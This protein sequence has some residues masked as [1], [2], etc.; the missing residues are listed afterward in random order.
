MR[1]RRLPA[2]ALALAL[3][4]GV[5][6]LGPVGSTGAAFS[7]TSANGNNSYSV[8]PD[9]VA[10]TVNRTV[11]AESGGDPTYYSEVLADAP[12]G[13][14]RL[15]ES[16]GTTAADSSGN[17]RNGTYSGTYTLGA[18]G[19][20]NA[21][22][23]AVSF[24]GA[25]SVNINSSTLQPSNA[26]TVEAWVK[27]AS[28][29]GNC[30]IFE[31][32]ANGFPNTS[33]L[34]DISGG[35]F[36]CRFYKW[37]FLNQIQSNA[38]FTADAWAHVAC[39][40]NG[41]TLRMYVNGVQQTA[42]AALSAPIDTGTGASRIGRL[43]NGTNPFY[44]TIDEVAVY[45]T[46]LSGTRIS[47]HYAAAGGA[48]PDAVRSCRYYYAYAGAT[49]TGN[50]ASGV[51]SL[52]ADLSS[53]SSGQS[54]V[55]L[56]GGSYPMQGVTYGYRSGPRLATSAAGS[57]TYSMT[58]TDNAANTRVQTGFPATVVAAASPVS[59][60]YLTGLEQGVVS[61]NAPGV[62]DSVTATG[63][64]ADATTRRNGAYSLRIAPANAA[65][66]ATA[67]AS[68][69]GSLAVIRFAVRLA[70]LPASTVNLM[71]LGAAAGNPAAVLAY[72][73][74]TG[75][76]GVRFESGAITTG[77]VAPAAGTWYVIDMK[78]DLN[79]R[80][81]NWRIDGVDQPP[82]TS[83]G[84]AASWANLTFGTGSSTVTYTANFDDV[85]ASRTSTDYPI[86]NGKVL[87]L[88]PNG[89]GTHS[90]PAFFQED[91]GTVIDASTWNRIDEVPAS[92]MSDYVRQVTIGTGS[93][94]GITLQDTTETCITAVSALVDYHSAY[95]GTNHGKTS[96]FNG[97]AENV[98]YDGNMAADST[99]PSYERAIV[100]P[101]GG[102]WT[103][104]QLNALFFR[105]GYSS[106]VTPNPYWDA[107]LVEYDVPTNW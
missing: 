7:S 58:S 107:L 71:S 80:T 37:G 93:Y 8:A 105:I 70:A 82:H 94:V 1:H 69:S 30:T 31:K 63:V 62:F 68:G 60:V 97:A 59:A 57:Y 89:M 29:C 4:L 19:G 84:T 100:A 45:S 46:G 86:G 78:A 90:N 43:V 81:V 32:S 36:R 88:A 16:S 85:I 15:G 28:S 51:A 79:S 22:N 72:D 75:R 14:W 53:L 54:A 39:S 47:A 98:V 103:T 77:M 21:V 40:W 83:T 33:F 52:T 35:L 25:G 11:I 74:G 27:P 2:V 61:M 101:A 92:S 38:S 95:V 3:A 55:A 24:A 42:T 34:M 6:V 44:G 49:D 56:S 102:G 17:G 99:P 20:I 26:A 87:A 23:T 50:P 66:Y 10:P 67:N 76:F 9:F 64:S 104:A 13:Y 18:A 5:A 106:D 41:T 65:A 48:Y 73:V 91:D 12:L 96:I